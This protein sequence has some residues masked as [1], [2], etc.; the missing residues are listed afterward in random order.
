MIKDIFGIRIFI[1]VSKV[2]SIE[3]NIDRLIV[4]T[5]KKTWKVRL[6]AVIVAIQSIIA[7]LVVNIIL[8]IYKSH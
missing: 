3:S 2:V 6:S 1:K 5:T 8:C 7:D 4:L